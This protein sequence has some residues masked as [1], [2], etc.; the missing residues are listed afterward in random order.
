[1]SLRVVP[2]TAQP[3]AGPPEATD[4][5]GR[6]EGQILHTAHL[7]CDILCVVEGWMADHLIIAAFQ[8]NIE[9]AIIRL[10]IA[11]RRA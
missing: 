2:V 5:A 7:F 9:Q 10:L 4:S 11:P 8:C 1:M 3:I 6:K